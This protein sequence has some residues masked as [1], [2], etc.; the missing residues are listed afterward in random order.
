MTQSDL[1]DIEFDHPV[2]HSQNHHID[3]PY[4]KSNIYTNGPHQ[5]ES[6]VNTSFSIPRVVSRSNKRQAPS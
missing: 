1:C 4:S 3:I 5:P 6:D 2:D